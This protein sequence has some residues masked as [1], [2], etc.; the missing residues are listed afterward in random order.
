MTRLDADVL[1]VGAGPAGSAAARVLAA[2]GL[3][4][5][6]VDR[7]AFPRDKIC[8][9]ALI[10]DALQAL[11]ALGLRE[12]VLRA[13]HAVQSV[14]VY[15][16][17]SRYAAIRGDCA[18]LPRTVLDELLRQSAVAEGARFLAPLRAVSP[19]EVD[20]VVNGARLED[21]RSR[22]GIE[23]RAPATILATGAAADVLR[24]FGMCLRA[25]PS[26]TAAR[27]YVRVPPGVAAAH[28]NLVISYE[29]VI[30][31]GYGWIFP[32]PDGTFNV[33]I[34]YVYDGP[35]PTERNVRRLLDRFLAVFPP[36]AAL[37][38]HALDVTPLKGAPLRTAMR[39]ARTSRPGLFVVGEAAG[40]TY[41][42]TGE[43]IGK[44]LQSGILAARILVET[45]G[46]TREH[47]Q[48]MADA[49]T[50]RLHADYGARFR[51]Y[52][53]LQ[54]WM[55]HP[56]IANLLVRRANRGR[57]VRSQLEALLNETGPPDGLLS[58]GG[59]IRAL[60]T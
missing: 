4:V 57:Y 27:C 21:P 10:P 11:D 49:F 3:H 13:A 31:P 15:S 55:A 48:L 40:L 35:S 42:F 43:G 25:R 58:T 44:A 20:G 6:L 37:M 8:G 33:G 39:G 23:V 12:R 53:R 22:S 46:R 45:R 50:R 56:A 59:I 9:D 18:C 51:A 2:A 24:R 7:H 1:V 32:G 52:A 5:V 26:A 34:G 17:E 29:S 36:A 14:R 30:C 60:L 28:D 41:S 54:S 16:P 19:I 47:L 38:R